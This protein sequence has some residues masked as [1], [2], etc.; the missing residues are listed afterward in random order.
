MTQD[1]PDLGEQALSKAVELGITS[2]LD[3]VE[4]LD[5]DIR[6][7]PL[8]L[9]QGKLD[10]VAIAGEGMVMKQDLRVESMELNTSSVSI[11]PLSIAFG[12]VELTQP[13]DATAQIVLTEADLNRALSSDYLRQ[14]MQNLELRIQ[15]RPVAID[16]Q[17]AI[18]G[19]PGDDR[20]SLSASIW[21]Q[22][23]QETKQ[24]SAVA[25]PS[26]QDNGQRIALEILSAEAQGLSLDFATA[27]FEKLMELLDL[28]NFELEGISLQLEKLNAYKG[29]LL[30]HAFTVVQ[31]IP[32][33]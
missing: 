10:S 20:F 8:K 21:L 5:V 22:E 4:G 28:R 1:K 13:T 19:L 33:F 11:N 23:T 31:Q 9:V 7:D 29:K 32:S 27:L 26:V 14:K 2:Q 30:L 25:K 15:N 18:L 12:K 6:T 17:Q 3:E 24:F 16:V